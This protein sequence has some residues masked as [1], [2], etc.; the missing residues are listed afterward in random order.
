MPKSKIGEFEAFG[1]FEANRIVI[2][3]EPIVINDNAFVVIQYG[4]VVGKVSVRYDFSDL[5]EKYHGM[6]LDIIAVTTRIYDSTDPVPASRV[7]LAK[8]TLTLLQRLRKLL[9]PSRSERG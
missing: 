5:P 9:V 7:E 1:E 6:M 3:S 4:K 8:P 2:D